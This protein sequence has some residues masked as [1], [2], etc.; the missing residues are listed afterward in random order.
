MSPTRRDIL[1]AGAAVVAGAALAS[2]DVMASPMKLPIGFQAFEIIPD[3]EKNFEGTLR[4]MAEIGFKFIDMVAWGPYTMRSAKA[5]RTSLA[6]AGLGCDICHWQYPAFTAQFG[7]AIAYSQALGVSAVVCAPG[8]RQTTTDDWKFQAD[9][10]NGLGE[11]TRKEGLALLY[12]NHDVEFE[13]TPQGQMPFDVLMANTDPAL[14]HVVLDVGNLTFGGGDPVA[15]LSKYSSR[16]V[17]LHAKDYER[18]KAAVPV[19]SGS[20]DWTRIFAI[21]KQANI[22]S[23]VAEVGAYSPR[24]QQNIMLELPTLGVI[25]LYRQSF[26]F[27]NGFIDT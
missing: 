19:G 9:E 12:H 14:L 27:L 17:S 24:R 3:L 23:I 4:N 8:P 16:V 21:A 7:P 20:V 10:M 6:G 26:A 18:G 1:A 25:D 15:Y 11:A 22:R 5:L 13:P 2:R